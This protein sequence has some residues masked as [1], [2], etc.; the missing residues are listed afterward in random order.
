VTDT[1]QQVETGSRNKACPECGTIYKIPYLY[2]HLRTVHN[3][4]GGE[5]GNAKAASAAKQA[6]RFPCSEPGCDRSFPKESG[7]QMHVQRAHRGMKGGS[8]KG[9]RRSTTAVMPA[10]EVVHA[11]GAG[12]PVRVM[13]EAKAGRR[14]KVLDGFLLIEDQ[15]DGSIYLAEKIRDGLH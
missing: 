7:L 11:N 1:A 15:V 4:Y 5:S 10:K 9:R 13:A 3:V 6:S 2:S 12:A 14:F 8:G